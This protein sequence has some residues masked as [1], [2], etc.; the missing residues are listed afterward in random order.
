MSDLK[1]TY[2]ISQGGVTYLLKDGTPDKV[3]QKAHDDAIKT[4]RAAQQAAT[5]KKRGG[6]T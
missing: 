1:Q 4:A 5:T 3:T 2:K 6:K